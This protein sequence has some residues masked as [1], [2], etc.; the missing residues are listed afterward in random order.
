MEPKTLSWISTTSCW[1]KP[2]LSWTTRPRIMM[3]SFS[4]FMPP[5]CLY[6]WRKETAQVIIRTIFT[7]ISQTIRLL[8][9][10]WWSNIFVSCRKYKVWEPIEAMLYGCKQ[11]IF[12]WQWGWEWGQEIY[13]LWWP[14]IGIL[15]G[16]GASYAGW[17]T[18]C[19][20]SFATHSF[21]F[22]TYPYKRGRGDSN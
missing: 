7:F 3:S 20:F 2:W 10:Y 5:S 22:W 21:F 19:V 13:N 14:W 6:S 4:I 8:V 15:L 18:C 9:F 16:H 11:R 17:M 1:N 12:L